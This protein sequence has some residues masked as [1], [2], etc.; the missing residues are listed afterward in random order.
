M[1]DPNSLDHPQQRELGLKL[2]ADIPDLCKAIRAK[3]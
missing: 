1:N 3:L 2:F